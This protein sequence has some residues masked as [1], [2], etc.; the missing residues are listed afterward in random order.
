MTLK[1][2]LSDGRVF[3]TQPFTN[4]IYN[5]DELVYKFEFDTVDRHVRS[6]A[7]HLWAVWDKVNKTLDM[8][9]MKDIKIEQHELL[10]QGWK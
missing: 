10:I 3:E 9:S 7:R 2:I 1:T 5:P 4:I 8:I 6:S